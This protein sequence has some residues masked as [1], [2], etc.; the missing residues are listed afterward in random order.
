MML[1]RPLALAAAL[2]LALPAHATILDGLAPGAAPVETTWYIAA[3][4]AG[5]AA[6]RGFATG[7]RAHHAGALSMSA[8]YLADPAASSPMLR[9]LAG[10]IIANQ[11]FEIGVLDRIAQD[12][13]APALV[14][15]GGLRLQAAGT[16]GMDRTARFFR[17]PPPGLLDQLGPVTVRDV[18]FAKAMEIH[19][20]GAL[21]MVR[22]WR[23]EPASRNGFL[24]QM[25]V[26][27]VA[28]QGFEIALLRRAVAAF[29]GD[30]SAIRIDP[31]MVHGMEGMRHSASS[32]VPAAQPAPPQLAPAQLAPAHAQPARPGETHG[33]HH[34]AHHGHAAPAA[35]APGP[36]APRAPA[37]AHRH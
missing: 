27:I 9:R 3:T 2:G 5:L 20:Q 33:G 31:S 11:S 12:L 13:S 17:A 29:P 25:G 18:Q 1:L 16:E 24:S 37:G 23:A 22:D 15:P 34:G 14:L 6:D 36:P 21:D 26:D 8:D 4:E 30:A 19:H 35:A 32:H 7:M 10:A 28:D